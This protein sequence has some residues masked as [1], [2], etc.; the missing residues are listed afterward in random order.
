MVNDTGRVSPGGTLTGDS[1][2][3]GPRSR[4]P[5]TTNVSGRAL[6]MVAWTRVPTFAL[7]SGPGTLGAAP[8]SPNASAGSATPVSLAGRHCARC[9]T[10]FTAVSYTHLRAHETP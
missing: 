6:R 9:A 3:P 1:F 2:D 4:R 10:S 7:S 8:S 5:D